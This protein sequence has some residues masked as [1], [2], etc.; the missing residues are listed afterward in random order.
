MA[1]TEMERAVRVSRDAAVYA[2]TWE[3]RRLIRKGS[4]ALEV[5]QARAHIEAA[6]A[7]GAGREAAR[8]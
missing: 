2:S 5:D 7:V 3:A 6:Y 4:V 1:E 8:A